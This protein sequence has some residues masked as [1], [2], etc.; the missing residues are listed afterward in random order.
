MGL[1][2]AND[3]SYEHDVDLGA[4]SLNTKCNVVLI[5]ASVDNHKSFKN[6]RDKW[7][8]RVSKSNSRDA[9]KILVMTN[10]QLYDRQDYRRPLVSEEEYQQMARD[11]DIES[12][13]Y[14]FNDRQD[15]LNVFEKAFTLAANRSRSNEL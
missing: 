4:N 9:V 1:F 5:C 12:C 6:V 13:E 14:H 8:R 7:L 2:N 15:A 11:L 10:A 3:H